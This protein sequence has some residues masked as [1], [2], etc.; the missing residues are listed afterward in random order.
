MDELFSDNL[1]ISLE[2]KDRPPARPTSETNCAAGGT[3]GAPVEQ[4]RPFWRHRHRVH[5]AAE[6]SPTGTWPVGPKPAGVRSP[7]RS[8]SVCPRMPSCAC[9]LDQPKPLFD[10][11]NCTGFLTISTT[12][13]C[14]SKGF[15]LRVVSRGVAALKNVGIM[16]MQRIYNYGSSLQGYGLRRLIEDLADDISVTF[17]DYEPGEVLVKGGGPSAPTSRLGRVVSKVREYNQVDAGFGDR[18]RFLN[19]KRTYGKRYLPLVGVT[20]EPNRDLDLDVQVIGSDEVFNCVQSN[21]NVGYSRDLFGHGSPVR[22]LISYAGS[23][24]NTTLEK[25]DAFGIRRELAEDF[26]RFASISVRDENSARI[27][28]ALT[29]QRPAV[30]VDPVLAYDFM[31]L[32]SSIPKQR[33]HDGRFIVV[34]GYGGRL[35]SEENKILSSYARSTGAEILCFGGVQGCCDRFVDC[36]PFELL[37]YFRDAEAIVTDTF[38]GT[39]FAIINNR[40]FATI[41]RRSIGHRYG[42]EEKLGYLLELFGLPSQRVTDMSTIAEILDHQVDYRQVNQT[43]DRERVR[44][45]DY[46]KSSILQGEQ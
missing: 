28:E 45:L 26:A 41:I 11:W 42:N 6:P 18:L 36:D 2:I 12:G 37:A 25:L 33:Q 44:T 39:I 1:Q 10:R 43:L 15:V 20:Q 16:S 46:L 21:T 4:G 23:F 31:S 30:N 17:V 40:P 7:G 8:N 13:T 22:R 38:H 35:S 9:L 27:I 29:G 14:R 3:A 5:K 34:Y 32:E 24:G 19:H